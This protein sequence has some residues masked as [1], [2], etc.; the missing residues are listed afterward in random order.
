MNLNVDV[1]IIAKS[2]PAIV[3]VAGLVLL[4]GS[5]SFGFGLGAGLLGFV[6]ML[7]GIGLFVLV[8]FLDRD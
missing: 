5:C 2:F 4:L 6:L 7:A 1:K 3:F 8:L